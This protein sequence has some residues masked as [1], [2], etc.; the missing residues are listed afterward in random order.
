MVS[1]LLE[2]LFSNSKTEVTSGHV[3][4]GARF[5]KIKCSCSTSRNRNL[6]CISLNLFPFLC[7]LYSSPIN[8]KKSKHCIFRHTALELLKSD[9][10]NA[11]KKKKAQLLTPKNRVLCIPIEFHNYRIDKAWTNFCRGTESG[12]L[13]AFLSWH[14]SHDR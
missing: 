12:N 8:E 9:K 10:T 5:E 6:F 1:K 2:F 4:N 13:M 14:S 7:I 3:K 11:K